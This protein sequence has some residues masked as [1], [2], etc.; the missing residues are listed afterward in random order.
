MIPLHT[1]QKLGQYILVAKSGEAAAA[2]AAARRAL[3]AEKISIHEFADTIKN[4]GTNNGKT[5][6]HELNGA[7]ERGRTDERREHEAGLQRSA[8][9]DVSLVAMAQ[10]LAENIYAVGDRHHGFIHDMAAKLARRH[11]IT[12]KQRSYLESLYFQAG[13]QYRE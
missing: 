1:A 7:Y 10:Y 4:P 2:M 11:R 8:D 6:Q 5:P 12:E 13:G 9:G 3:D